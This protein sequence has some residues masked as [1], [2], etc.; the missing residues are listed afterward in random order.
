M[1]ATTGSAARV[2]RQFDPATA[3]PAP[4]RAPEAPR[5]RIVRSP[6]A[7]RSRAPFV[8]LCVALVCAAMATVL[9]LNIQMARDSFAASDVQVRVAQ[10][11]QDVQRIRSELDAAA[12][13]AELAS[14]SR[15]LGMV[16]QEAQAF[17]RLSDGTVL[18]VPAAEGGRG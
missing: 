16:P 12:S 9:V 13:P 17:L 3:A 18:G 10:T 4:V 1:S 6:H 5:L 11:A 8:L 15:S 7:D 14:R 2:L